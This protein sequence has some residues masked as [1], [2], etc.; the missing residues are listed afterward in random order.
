MEARLLASDESTVRLA[1]AGGLGSFLQPELAERARA[2]LLSP[3]LRVWERFRIMFHQSYTPELR[4]GFSEWLVAHQEPLAALMAEGDVQ[5]LPQLLSGC[6]EQEARRVAADFAP[7]A[8][9]YPS[10]PFQLRKAEERV[11]L[12]ATA[13]AVQAPSVAG[14]L[15]GRGP[16]VE[17]PSPPR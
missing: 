8:R 5:D 9:T 4:S 1:L 11:R 13:R 15:A 7:L 10:L 3:R 2:L 17:Q 16:H 12:C 14:F 6:S